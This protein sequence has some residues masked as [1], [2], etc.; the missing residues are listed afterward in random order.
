MQKYGI[1]ILILLIQTILVAQNPAVI[2][3]VLRPP[4]LFVEFTYAIT[5]LGTPVRSANPNT[6]VPIYQN[7]TWGVY[8]ANSQSG[9]WQE[10]S[11]IETLPLATTP[12]GPLGM[13][14]S[15][16]YHNNDTI[17]AF[18]IGQG[19]FPPKYIIGRRDSFNIIDTI[20]DLYSVADPDPRG[21]F[22]EDGFVYFS[23]IVSRQITF[24]GALRTVLGNDIC[25]LN[26]NTA[27]LDTIFNWFDQVPSAMFIEEYWT[28]MWVNNEVDWP[29]Y[30]WITEDFDGDLLV[31]WR[32]MG[33]SKHDRE[34]GSVIW[35]GG[36]PAGLASSNGFQELTCVSGD[37]R[38]RL[39]HHINPFP[40]KP[41]WYSLFDNG[42]SSR[43]ASRA[44]I[45]SVD[46]DSLMRVEEEYPG[47]PSPFMGSVD[48]FDQDTNFILVNTPTF[49]FEGWQDTFDVWGMDTSTFL[50]NL[51]SIIPIAGSFIRLI[52]RG[53]NPGIQSGDVVGAWRTD[54]LNFVY[55]ANLL[56]YDIIS[57]IPSETQNNP[58]KTPV[59]FLC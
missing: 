11:R 50:Q 25:R 46:G 43:P 10:A 59:F 12:F 37:C 6:P 15:F 49:G 56:R 8:A 41:G 30:N 22:V 48:V 27:E 58:V 7:P 33:F 19:A 40:F 31:S 9:T 45:F 44:L 26:L 13:V 18:L 57:S 55:T 32:H 5:P 20:F 4:G 2:R 3:E 16:Q 51:E 17:S 23:Q 47:E 38:T 53:N 21:V 39:N 35:W 36:M 28:E 29:H 14:S 1:F 24:N 52:G 54:S 42:D 34:T